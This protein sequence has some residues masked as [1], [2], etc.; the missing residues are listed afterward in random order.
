MSRRRVE[1]DDDFDLVNM[2]DLLVSLTAVLLVMMPA[3]LPELATLVSRLPES[4]GATSAAVGERPATVVAFDAAGQLTWNDT[5]VDWSG[6]AARVAAHPV[7]EP[8]Q[9][10]GANDAPYGVSVRIRMALQQTGCPLT[11]LA[12]I[13]EQ[14][15]TPT[16]ESPDA[17]AH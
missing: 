4:P 14:L 2:I 11:E 6:F 17:P 7:D 3:R 1:L 15:L 5:P 10:A 9:I 16:Q 8:I 12:R 13:P